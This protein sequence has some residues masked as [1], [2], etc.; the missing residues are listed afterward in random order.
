MS[1]PELTHLADLHVHLGSAA[2]AH[3]LWELAH[4]R[5]IVLPE[6]N[7]WKF[8]ELV[9]IDHKIGWET[10]HNY[11]DMTQMIQS[12]PEAVEH[13]IHEAISLSYRKSS[14]D[15]LEIRFNPMRRNGDRMYDLDRI[16]LSATV[17]MRKAMMEYPVQ[18]GLI[19]EMDRR[20]DMRQNEIIVEKAIKFRHDGVVG[21]DVSGP[22]CD[23]FSMKEIAILT[24]KAKSYGLGITIHTGEAQPVEEVKEVLKYIQ[25]DRIGHGI[26][27]V[28]DITVMKELRDKNITLE[29]CPSSN[30]TLSVVKNWAEMKKTIRTLLDNEVKV[31]INSDGPVFLQTNVKEEYQKL[32]DKGILTLDEVED[33]NKNAHQ[34]SFINKQ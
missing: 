28:D 11:F 30:V 26:R 7:Y 22:N 25:P 17:G 8:L 12:S 29:V 19:L 18:V 24:E 15:L 5:G 1:Q 23:T 14:L 2:T 27:S 16:L 32:L 10:Y 9:K 21:I 33:C 20:F 6:K 3:L 34:A 31:T 4:Q 13:S